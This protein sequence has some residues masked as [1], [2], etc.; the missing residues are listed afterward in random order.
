MP[1][2]GT[3]LPG[4]DLDEIDTNANALPVPQGE[5][6]SE[7]FGHFDF[8]TRALQLG[9]ELVG[10]VTQ[11]QVLDPDTGFTHTPQLDSDTLNARYG[12]PGYLRFNKPDSEAD[13]AFQQSQAQERRFRDSVFARTNPQPLTDFGAGL[14]G[15]LLDPAGLATMW[16]TGG[17]GEAALGALGLKTAAEAAPAVSTLGRLA[18]AGGDVARTL[19]TGAIDNVPYVAANALLSHY[20]GDDYD[21]AD[22]LRDIAAGAVLHTA[23]HLTFRGAGALWD[24]FGAGLDAD[25]APIGGVPE[26]PPPFSPDPAPGMPPAVAAMGDAARRGAWVKALDDMAEDRPVDVA[27]YVEREVGAQPAAPETEVPEQ[28]QGAPNVDL[29]SADRSTVDGTAAPE[30]GAGVEH[31]P[32]ASPATDPDRVHFDQNHADLYRLGEVIAD[33]SAPREAIEA[34]ATRLADTMGRYM[35]WTDI[36]MSKA[37]R[38][39]LDRTG[40]PPAIEM[41]RAAADYHREVDIENAA[42]MSLYDSD[43]LHE[44]VTSERGRA[45]QATPAGDPLGELDAAYA[46]AAAGGAIPE[47][48]VRPPGEGPGAPGGDAHPAVVDALQLDRPR[49]TEGAAGARADPQ[50]PRAAFRARADA[51]I[52]ADPELKALLED[53]QRLAGRPDV[54]DEPGEESPGPQPGAKLQTSFMTDAKPVGREGLGAHLIDDLYGQPAGKPLDEK[55]AALFREVSDLVKRIAPGATARPFE[56]LRGEG[57]AERG[58]GVMGASYRKGA[59]QILAWSLESPDAVGTARHEA[60]HALREMGAFSDEEWRTLERAAVDQDWLGRYNIE[61]LYPDDG[62]ETHLEEAIAERFR[63]WRREPVP[64]G[65][66]SN[67]HEV[68]QRLLDLLQRLGAAARS[69]LGPNA[70]DILDAV[71]RGEVGA[72][73][74]ARPAKGKARPKLQEAFHG[75]PFDFDRFDSGR[76]GDGEGRQA[77]GHGLYFAGKREVAEHYREVLGG[78]GY[79]PEDYAE[80][81]RPGRIIEGRR[82]RD[83]VVAFHPSDIDGGA[84]WSVTVRSVGRNGEEIAG[85]RDRNHSTRPEDSAME[86]VL[87]RPP[88]LFGKLYHVDIPNDFEYLDWDKPLSAQPEFVKTALKN[89]GIDAEEKQDL[90]EFMGE[91]VEGSPRTGRDLYRD[92]G[93]EARGAGA[94]RGEA[95]RAAAARLREAGIAGVRYLDGSSRFAGDGTHNYVVFDDARVVPLAKYQRAQ[96]AQPPEVRAGE[97]VTKDK[98][99]TLV[100]AIRA[101]AIC[102]TEE[103]G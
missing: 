83:R 49:K 69:A 31:D 68:F 60:I 89:A 101:A 26:R 36:P 51:V 44:A 18:N 46:K 100:E 99:N 48:T 98:L 9:R 97:A 12:V 41:R 84:H 23:A 96:V 19:A 22:G 24:R 79:A 54:L 10:D 13:A 7:A 29:G 67:I 40:A 64:E 47:P 35:D 81:F 74:T 58:Q 73:D 6:T 28:E 4:P 34:E 33:R 103:L 55:T 87:G 16:A 95:S 85:E 91:R 3:Y 1:V 30:P 86:R 102:V 39:V 92:L 2:G 42:G 45:A 88:K 53:T 61:Q 72:R 93:S 90:G 80:Y 71:D 52:A 5:R 66:P 82:G 78:K 32:F 15:S 65:L 11:P 20:A 76:I 37:A 8:T 14:A 94:S 27:Q 43:R 56:F 63:E 17:A 38:R 75:S 62:W 21:L 50:E 77:Y 25:A 59:R 57:Q 70:A